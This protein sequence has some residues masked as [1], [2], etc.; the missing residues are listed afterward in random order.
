MIRYRLACTERRPRRGAEWLRRGSSV[1]VLWLSALAALAAG[2][3]TPARHD[4]RFD[5]VDRVAHGEHFENPAGSPVRTSI[6]N[7]LPAM[8]ASFV[9]HGFSAQ[10]RS[11]AHVVPHRETLDG[12]AAAAGTS[13]I[14]WIGHMTALLSIDGR[15]VLTDPWWSNHASPIPHMGPKRF[16]P[17]ALE[18]DELP[19][20]D[21]VI[22]SHSHYDHLDLAA[23]RNLPNRERTTAVVP[24]GLG[25]F[26]RGRGYRA[27]IELDWQHSTDVAGLRVTALPA[28]HWSSRGLVK[29]ND[30]LWASFAIEGPSGLRVY[31]GGDSD[32]GPV[33]ADLASRWGGFDVALLSIGGF[34]NAGV[35]CAPEQCVR[36][37][38][39][40]GARV[41][42]PLHWGTIY[43]GEGPPAELPA[44]F[45]A[46]AV[47]H[48]F[49]PVDVWQLKIGETR[50]L[51]LHRASPS[52]VPGSLTVDT[53]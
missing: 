39:D 8:I 41:I 37:G 20:I 3:A 42:V 7:R 35:H 10:T 14:T 45:T 51:P 22:V 27:V 46:A 49:D 18:L 48:G 31:F 2:C 33:H 5:R 47:G 9:R 15:H 6:V 12:V 32:Y 26:F 28:I 44:R 52:R 43:L 29:K 50:A 36:I 17:P 23:I 13:S 19:P 40:L 4:D 1:R 53:R 21:V 11:Q 34:H 38:M 16:V 24:L 25:R 30:T